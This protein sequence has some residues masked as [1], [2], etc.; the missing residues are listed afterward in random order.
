MV[1]ISV[2]GGWMSIDFIR[3]A[4]RRVCQINKFDGMASVPSGVATSGLFFRLGAA[5]LTVI[6]GDGDEGAAAGGG[7]GHAAG[8]VKL[9]GAGANRG[10]RVALSQGGNCKRE[11]RRRRNGEKETTGGELQL[12]ALSVSPGTLSSISCSLQEKKEERDAGR[13]GGDHRDVRYPRLQRRARS[14]IT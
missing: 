14:V 2:S 7:G 10:G 11:D 1:G 12:K 6:G 4:W 8:R 5:G 3:M 9:K 13:I